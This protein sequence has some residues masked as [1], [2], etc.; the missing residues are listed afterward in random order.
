M[1]ATTQRRPQTIGIIGGGFTGLTAAYRLLQAGYQVTVFERS[2]QVGGLAMTFPVTAIGGTRLEKYYHHLFTS[3][4]DYIMISN[5]FTPVGDTP[6]AV[7]YSATLS[8]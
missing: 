5:G 7:D 3:D 6:Q 1:I 8:Q 4:V 2:H